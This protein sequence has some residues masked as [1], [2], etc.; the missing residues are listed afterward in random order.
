MPLFGGHKKDS[1]KLHREHDEPQQFQDP[2]QT[3][4]GTGA[5][6]GMTG[7]SMG[8]SGAAMG[9]SNLRLLVDVLRTISSKVMGASPWYGGMDAQ[10]GM[11]G[12]NNNTGYNDNNNAMIGWQPDPWPHAS[13]LTCEK[14]VGSM[15]GSNAVKAKVMQKEMEAKA[16]KSQ[17]NELAEAER[18]EQEALARRERAVAHGAHPDN[19][20]LGG[21]PNL[22][23][24]T[25]GN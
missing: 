9:D 16:L 2:N 3:T 1:K 21:I 10:P 13:L 22:G 24:R 7:S 19:R 18:L 11:G 12:M 17:S 8:G 15:V 25:Q 23:T 5:A 20:H 6:G 4:G 14:G